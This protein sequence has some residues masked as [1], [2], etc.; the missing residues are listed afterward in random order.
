MNTRPDTQEDLSNPSEAFLRSIDIRELLPQREP[1][2]MVDT[3]TIHSGVRT[4]TE[5]LIRTDNLFVKDDTLIASGL[6]ENLAQTCAARIGY[7]NKYVLQRDI[8]IGVVAAIKQLDIHALPHADSVITTSITI[9]HEM[10]GAMKATAYTTCQGR[11]LL[12][13]DITIAIK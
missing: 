12:T 3:L 9:K 5:T 11:K 10:E 1:Y 4:T 7:I 8:S 6:I 13:A 2:L